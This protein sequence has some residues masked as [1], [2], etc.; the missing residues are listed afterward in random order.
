[1]SL[2]YSILNKYALFASASAEPTP[3][4]S[5]TVYQLAIA[6]MDSARETDPNAE[7]AHSS[8]T[9][10]RT[11]YVIAS[12]LSDKIVEMEGERRFFKTATAAGQVLRQIQPWKTCRLIFKSPHESWSSESSH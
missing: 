12:W 10:P 4:G 8:H 3:R 9:H 2:Y 6:D 7:L 1:M 11:P 5:W